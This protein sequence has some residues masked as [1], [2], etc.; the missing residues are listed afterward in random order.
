[1]TDLDFKNPTNVLLAEFSLDDPVLYSS[2]EFDSCMVITDSLNLGEQRLLEVD[3][4]LVVPCSIGLRFLITS[5]D[6]LHA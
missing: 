5:A 3:N 2:F 1:M 6:V 4:P